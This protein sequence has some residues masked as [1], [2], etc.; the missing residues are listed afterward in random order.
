VA[1]TVKPDIGL[2]STKDQN[3]GNIAD[4]HK[5]EKGSGDDAFSYVARMGLVYLYIDVKKDVDQDI[6]T[7]PP[8]G[9]PPSDYSF[10]VDTWNEEEKHWDR[11]SALGQNAYYAHAVQTRQFRTHVFSLTISGRT[12]RIMCWDRSGVLVTEAFDYKANPGILIEFVWRFIRATQ[13][14]QGFDLT[15]AS[16]DSEEDRDSFLTAIRSHVQL[17][18]ALDPMTDKEELN[19]EVDK[20]CFQ[21]AVA[22][23]TIGNYDIWVSRPLWLSR[24]IVGRCT[25]GYWGVRCDT[26]AVVFVK[27]VWHTNVKNV[28]PEGNILKDLQE[29]GVG[30]IPTVLCHG[31][32]LNDEGLGRVSFITRF[33]F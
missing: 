23:L 25:A 32:V 1:G 11:I 16:V 29:K 24:A 9:L 20:H 22:R 2:Y 14:Q 30:H 31:D 5:H 21:G 15:A 28:E 6:F 18:L 3:Q 26:K 17:Q 19:R 10:T 8:E 4:F 12:A 27:D 13:A 7:D 33:G